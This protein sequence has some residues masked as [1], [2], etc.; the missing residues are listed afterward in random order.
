MHA[1]SGGAVCEPLLQRQSPHPVRSLTGD[2]PQGTS[3]AGADL[4]PK[5]V[6]PGAS[7]WSWALGLR[8]GAWHSKRSVPGFFVS[9]KAEKHRYPLFQCQS[10]APRVAPG[11]LVPLAELQGT[12]PRGHGCWGSGTAQQPCLLC[13][14]SP[15]HFSA[16]TPGR[17]EP[18]PEG[19]SSSRI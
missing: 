1:T 3:A 5:P 11:P 13:A 6:W 18:Q 16:L 9:N 7:A 15:H 8:G 14:C 12:L 2:R 10:A 4:T 19:L 17:A